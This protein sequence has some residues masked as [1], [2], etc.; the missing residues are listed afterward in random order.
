MID[1]YKEK[2]I[3]MFVYFD[4]VCERNGLRYYAIGGT[5]LGAI[6]HKGFIP[7][8]NDIDVAMPR[9]DYDRAVEIINSDKSKYI[10]E[11]PQSEAPDYLYSVAKMYDTTT[12]LIEDL[13]VETIRGV[14][15]DVFP[16]DG[17]GNDKE[18]INEKYRRINTMNNLFAMRTCSIRS[19]RAWWKN[20]AIRFSS[21]VPEK[22][23]N[24]KKLLMKMDNECR[25]Y[26]FEDSDYVGVLLTQYGTKYIMPK[27][28]F[29]KTKRYQFEN[30]TIVGVEDYNTYLTLLFGDWKKLPPKEKQIEGH[31]YKFVDLN[32]SYLT[33]EKK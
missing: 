14:Y 20:L 8:D 2:L 17:M 1:G 28:L 16:M 11:T 15:I 23:L 5:F 33:E 3:E 9:K 31:D 22:V 12:T 7:W 6:R 26:S 29:L 25:K 24:T 27:E 30:T 19:Q 10:M 4:Q 18:L 32:R 13:K 21:V